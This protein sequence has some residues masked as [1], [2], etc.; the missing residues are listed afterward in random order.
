M[1][2]ILSNPKAQSK[3]D[4]FESAENWH[5]LQKNHDAVQQ[6]SPKTILLVDSSFRGSEQLVDTLENIG[7]TCEVSRDGKQALMTSRL[8]DFPLVAI[9]RGLPDVSGE[10]LVDLLKVHKLPDAEF[11][12]LSDETAETAA[13]KVEQVFSDHSHKARNQE[14]YGEILGTAVFE[15]IVRLR[16]KDESTEY[17]NEKTNRLHAVFQ[18]EIKRLSR[19]DSEIVRNEEAFKDYL[20]DF[21]EREE[22]SSPERLLELS[23]RAIQELNQ[24]GVSKSA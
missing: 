7:F 11:I 8:K 22:S 9:R 24:E 20:A 23:I 16:R 6:A 12:F 2:T 15:G 3:I 13:C 14:F 5:L 17:A 4:L 21:L 1:K 19:K 10:D 18:E